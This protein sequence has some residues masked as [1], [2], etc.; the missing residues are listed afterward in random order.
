MN[1]SMSIDKY[2]ENKDKI[3]GAFQQCERNLKET[4][5]YIF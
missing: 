2:A 1:Y 5:Q 3:A 4:D